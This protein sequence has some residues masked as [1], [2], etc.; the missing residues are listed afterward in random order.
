MLSC[1]LCCCNRWP[2]MQFHIES[3]Q[4]RKAEYCISRETATGP[5]CAAGFPMTV[6]AA[7]LPANGDRRPR[8]GIGLANTI[9]RLR[10]LTQ[11][12]TTWLFYTAARER[13]LLS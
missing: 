13:R 10:V 9:K 2:R 11:K 4:G 7:R 1:L 3:L 6:W 5:A 8:H 12:I